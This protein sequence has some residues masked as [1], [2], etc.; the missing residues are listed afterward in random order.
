MATFIQW[1]KGWRHPF[2]RYLV[3]LGLGSS[4]NVSCSFPRAPIDNAVAIDVEHAGSVDAGTSGSSGWLCNDDAYLPSRV[5]T[6][7]LCLPNASIQLRTSSSPS[8]TGLDDSPA[9]E[10]VTSHAIWLHGP[11]EKMI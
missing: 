8:S 1:E 9:P 4:S 2:K 11:V 6:G 10:S 3:P 5:R 7:N